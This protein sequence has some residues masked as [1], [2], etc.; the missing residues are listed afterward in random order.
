[1]DNILSNPNYNS[2]DKTIRVFPNPVQNMIS[3][4]NNDPTLAI[5]DVILYDILGVQIETSLNN[6]TMD[7]SHLSSGVYLMTINTSLGV[8]TRRV[9]KE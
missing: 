1:M 5:Q 3:I 8:I 9:I 6:G 7:L 4:E 2:L